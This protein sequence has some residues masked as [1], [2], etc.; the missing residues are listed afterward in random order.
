MMEGDEALV[1]AQNGT[2]N[3][4]NVDAVIERGEKSRVGYLQ[5]LDLAQRRRGYM[6]KSYADHNRNFADSSDT[7]YAAAQALTATTSHGAYRGDVEVGAM[8]GV[9]ADHSTKGLNWLRD[10][11]EDGGSDN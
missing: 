3:G 7:F 1:M 10:A 6:E 2:T 11:A 8:F 4:F 5:R 9:R